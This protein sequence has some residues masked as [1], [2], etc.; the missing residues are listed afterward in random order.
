MIVS[1]PVGGT[2]QIED[3]PQ[4]LLVT[5]HLD[6][7][8]WPWL[9]EG[10]VLGMLNWGPGWERSNC[11][12][13][14]ARG[15]S[16]RKHVAQKCNLGGVNQSSLTPGLW[17]TEEVTWVS[18]GL[19][20]SGGGA[21][22]LQLRPRWWLRVLEGVKNQQI[23]DPRGG[24]GISPSSSIADP[25][26]TVDFTPLSP[27]YQFRWFW[28]LHSGWASWV[29][30]STFTCQGLRPMGK[31]GQ[32]EW[33]PQAFSLEPG[34]SHSLR[35]HRSFWNL[36]KVMESFPRKTHIHIISY[37]QYEGSQVS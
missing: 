5:P 28:G 1:Q 25:W 8:V 19:V 37:I 13:P 31:G 6:S 15:P 2:D 30:T 22:R 10:A 16:G 29:G 33:V 24:D 20:W 35:E 26:N 9:S 4:L 21:R 34:I 36:M 7:Y 12:C 11:L 27:S 18:L 14:M 32:F 23:Q 17:F 3:H